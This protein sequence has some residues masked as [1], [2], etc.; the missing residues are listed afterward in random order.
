MIAS[1][2]P[3]LPLPVVLG[4]MT[5]TVYSQSSFGRRSPN[6]VGGGESA[7]SSGSSR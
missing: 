6:T 5:L 4:G 7:E 2:L 3:P 1:M